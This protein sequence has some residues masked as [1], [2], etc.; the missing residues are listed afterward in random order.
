MKDLF[1]RLLDYYSIT[2][3]EFNCLNK[4][5]NPQSFVNNYRFDNVKEAVKLVNS[6]IQNKKK[7][8]I[9]GDYDADGIMGT[10]ILVKTLQYLSYDATY[11]IPSRYKDGYGLNMSRAKEIVDNGIGLLICVDNGISAIEPIAYC[12]EHNVDVLVL[13]HHEIP[14]Q[15]PNANVIMHPFMSNFKENSTSGASTAFFFSIYM[16]KRFDKYLSTLASISIISD[17]MPLKGYNR[18][19]LRIVFP[20]YIDGEFY[21]ID[22]LKGSDTFDE[23]SIGMSIA[24]K[25]NSVG[26]IIEDQSINNIVKYF[27]S[28]DSEEVLT[29]FNWINELNDQRKEASKLSLDNSAEIKEDDDAIV[30]QVDEKEGLIGLI[31]NSLMNKFKKP[32]IVFTYNKEL[33]VLKGSARSMEGFNVVDSFNELKD[34]MVAYGG[35]ASAGGCSIKRDDFDAFKKKFN[36]FAKKNPI[37]H[38]EKPSIPISITEITF[39]NYDLI[40]KFGPFG[41]A[42]KKPFFNLENIRVGSLKYSKDLKHIITQIGTNSKITG[43]NISK[44]SL[45]GKENVNFL[46]NL[47]ISVYKSTKSLE[48]LISEVKE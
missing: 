17:M 26:R 4:D 42:W 43:F 40:Q 1:Q 19:L 9:Y 5:V 47:R 12:R 2:E 37:I 36:D 25:I 11:C 20:R 21:Q 14:E 39:E 32:T 35:H 33:D 3:D 27:I 34:F 24:P 38:V 44:D 15:I 29:Y 48:F 23:N 31:A 13:D 22:L 10:S 7:I 41:E 28:N 6:A 30:I 16:L 46:G 45:Y 18:D 8:H